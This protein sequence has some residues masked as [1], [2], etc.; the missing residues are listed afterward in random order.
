M[1]EQQDRHANSDR[2]AL[3]AEAP[4]T[5]TESE[6]ETRSTAG[7]PA[8]GSFNEGTAAL[9][10]EE[11]SNERE[12]RQKVGKLVTEK[13]DGDYKKAFDHYDTSRGG[14]IGKSELVRLLSD[15]G[16]GNGLTRGAW[17]NGIIDKLD[18]NMDHAIDWS[19]FESVFKA[20]A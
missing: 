6:E 19:E 5:E 20:T 17:A 9:A 11:D 7:K 4:E 8:A 14:S 13:F 16:V 1:R 3:K 2:E 10:Y 12:L 18:R 15:A